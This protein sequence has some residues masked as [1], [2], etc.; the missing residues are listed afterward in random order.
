MKTG[1]KLIKQIIDYGHPR[2]N[3]ARRVYLKCISSGRI[4]IAQR[5]EM[6]YGRVTT[7]EEILRTINEA[8]TSI[9]MGMV[10]KICSN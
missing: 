1:R 6:K 4:D 2:F 5:I 9:Q 8:F 7:N 10:N 3:K